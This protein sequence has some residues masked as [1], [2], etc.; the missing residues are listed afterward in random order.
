MKIIFINYSDRK[1]GASIVAN[2]LQKGLSHQFQT[3]NYFL[4][5]SQKS[6]DP[7]VLKILDNRFQKKMES[8]IN[9]ITRKLGLQY[10]YFPFSS[11]SILRKVKELKPDV[12]SLHN[13]HDGYF[14]TSILIELSKIAP[15]VWT[16]HDM[17]SF[18][19]NCAH[20][21]GDESWKKM[22]SGKHY[23]NIYPQIGLN[24]GSWLLKQK[25]KIYKKS[26]LTIVTPSK[27]LYHLAKQSP[28]FENI[29]IQHIFNGIDLNFFKHYD[30]KECRINLKI[31]LDA[32][33]L[34]FSGDGLLANSPWKGGK[35]LINILRLINSMVN[36]KI[37][38]LVTG[39]GNIKELEELDNFIIH[40][41]GYIKD[42]TFMTTC[43]SAA[44]ILIYPTRADNLPNSLIESIACARPAIVF[45]IGG[46]GE[47][48]K[49]NVNG[50]LIKPFELR[51][52]ADKVIELLYDGNKLL[53]LS[54]NARKYAEE[55]FSIETMSNN[56]FNLFK[57]VINNFVN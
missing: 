43:L 6:N 1:G 42:Q 17:W 46:C 32:K 36:E 33:V 35:D 50:F 5:A 31:P 57:K 3:D 18:T 45:D 55:K 12:I 29:E 30:K 25:E 27:W 19:G 22:Q 11:K 13:T 9:K 52:F 49:D 51:E 7:D 47:I 39:K 10:Q 16:L 15:V 48:I 38:L 53:E 34:I 41:T 24:T 4:V 14:Q 2:R 28:V 26:I 54:K 8:K 37:Y 21:F 23:K 20:T 56:Y 40:K 44:D